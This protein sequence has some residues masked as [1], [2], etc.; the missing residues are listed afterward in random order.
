[1]VSVDNLVVSILDFGL[2]AAGSHVGTPVGTPFGAKKN[3]CLPKRGAENTS[4]FQEP[5]V[6][7][8]HSLKIEG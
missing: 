1:M 5:C 3:C 6:I 7:L 2:A 4:S 8:P